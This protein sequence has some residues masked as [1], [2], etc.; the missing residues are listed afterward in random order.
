MPSTAPEFD[1]V[2]WRAWPCAECRGNT[3]FI[4]FLNGCY[5]A[6]EPLS[7]GTLD[8]IIDEQKV[9][10][11]AWLVE[12]AASC[13]HHSDSEAKLVKLKEGSEHLVYYTA[14]GENV[15]KL[16][17]LGTFGESYFI[18][19]NR[20]HQRCCT[21]GDYFVRL[22]TLEE[23]FGFAADTIGI[24]PAGQIVTLQRFVTG[25]H[26]TQAEA[27][28]FLLESGLE[29]VKQNCFIWKRA[30]EEQGIEFWVGDARDENFVKTP[31]GIVP[32]DLRMWTVD[33][34]E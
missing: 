18:V 21:P 11:A 19:N 3:S 6:G 1:I 9:R 33:L 8:A 34:N 10:E 30:A 4:D 28:A 23:H 29:P 16:T 31:H 32:I 24:T 27:D 5:E 15:L 12:W 26:P 22:Q 14:Q 13:P 7:D 25:E 17:K 20:A 2:R